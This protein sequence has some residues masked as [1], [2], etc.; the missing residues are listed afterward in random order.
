[1]TRKRG[2]CVLLTVA[3]DYRRAVLNFSFVVPRTLAGMARPGLFG[4]LGEDLAFI[5]SE[6]IKAILSLSEL[7]LDENLLHAEGFSYLHVP[8]GDFTAPTLEQVEQCVSFIDRMIEEENKPVAIHC[9]AGCGRTGTILAC[10]LVKKAS[11]AEK[12][13]ENVRSKR[14]C[15]IETDTQRVLVYRYEEYLK[16]RPASKE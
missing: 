6:G 1:M 16:H 3:M 8:V 13:I 2:E 15:S 4:Q 14:P 11:T 9:G 12:A 7:P 5:K 10:Y